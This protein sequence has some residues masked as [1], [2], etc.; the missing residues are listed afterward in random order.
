[1]SQLQIARAV[2]GTAGHIDHGKSSLVRAL[3]GRD[4]DRLQEEKAREL[5]ID[6]GF[7]PL[8]LDGRRVGMIDVPG[9]ERFVKN[10][11]AGATGIDVVLLVVAADDGVMPQTREHLEILTLLGIERGMIA[12]TKTDLPTVD[13][14]LLEL[15]E[16]DVEELVQGTFLEG[17]PRVRVS[18]HTGAGLD[19]LKETL[20]ALVDQVQPRPVDGPFRLPI[21]RVFSAKGFGTVLTGVPLQGR[22]QVGDV[23]EVL[24]HKGTVLKGKV[25]GLQAYG[26]KVDRVEAGHSSAV[27]LSDVDRKAVTRGD[28]VA[29]PGIFSA[30]DL[31]EVR[32]HHLA[33]QTRPLKQRE[34]VRFH[35]GTSEVLGEV[36]ILDAPELPPGQDAMCQLRLREKVVAAPGDRCVVRRHSP[37]QTL[38]GGTVLGASKW[39][40]KPGKR[41]VLERLSQKETV[42]GDDAGTLILALD[43]DATPQRADDLVRSL[44]RPKPEV[45]ALLE[46][47]AQDGR[48]VEVSG[49]KG[50]P[51]YVSRE[52]FAHARETLATTLAAYHREHPCRASCARLELRTRSK[53]HDMLFQAALSASLEAGDVVQ[54]PAGL[55]A[56][57][58]SVELPE[59]AA[60]YAQRLGALFNAR[61]FQPPTP[62][63]AL[64]ELA[65]ELDATTTE[66]VFALLLERGEL[67]QIADD[68]VFHGERYA[69][70][71]QRV[72][73]SIQRDG[74]LSA[75]DFKTQIDSSRRYTI[76]LLEHF[77]QIRLTKREGDVRVLR[78]G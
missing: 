60:D 28:V 17:A 70:A 40:L 14:D 1:M 72:I 35:V 41:F 62:A 5:T 65:P 73:E 33:S 4:P 44:G 18:A 23:L 10:M 53:L 2:V 77:D 6:L 58:F 13:E 46:E 74:P 75:A 20:G 31:W 12:I 26:E 51:A 43:G 61:A 21:Q 39:R 54:T 76:P 57:A 63:Q 27:N 24:T 59:A 42:L 64:E 78:E 19:A 56:A 32:L 25:R 48:A 37:M 67:V 9:H 71:K 3:T 55:A 52:A 49:G 22:A 69:E 47:L 7:A 15:V 8:D 16:L 30:S 50:N 34:T 66:D 68:V 29:T 11:V 45:L 36:V 38:G